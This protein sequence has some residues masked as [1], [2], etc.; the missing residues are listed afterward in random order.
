[1]NDVH[2]MKLALKL[3][4]KGHGYTS[5]NPMVG[6][7]LVKQNRIIGQGYHQ[8]CGENYA[9]VNAIESAVENVEGST[10]HVTLEPCCHQG[11]TPPCTDRIIQNK[12][13]Q[14]SILGNMQC[15]IRASG[16]VI[17]R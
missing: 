17:H 16:E 15:Q 1:M 12:R 3:A 10:L 14:L 9:E 2:Y 6:A 8:C 4:A 13:N 5:P 7:V 11:K